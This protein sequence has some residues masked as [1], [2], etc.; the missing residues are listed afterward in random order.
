GR[1]GGVARYSSAASRS[2]LAPP[3][4]RSAPAQNARP[5][6]VTT[7]ARTASSASHAANASASSR[8]IVGVYAFSRSGRLSVIT[9]TP[10]RTSSK[11]S[12]KVSWCPMRRALRSAARRGQDPLELGQERRV[13]AD[14]PEIGPL[15]DRRLRILVD[16]DDDAGT[17]ETDQVLR[18]PADG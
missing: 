4:A 6:P 10:S 14:D 7:I 13:V 9:A 3:R 18:G 17:P 5:A 11:I 15:E 1:S 16:R 2:K 8:P 12:S